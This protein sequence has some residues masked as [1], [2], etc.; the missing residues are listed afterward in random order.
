MYH[1]ND[2][3]KLF[4]RRAMMLAGGKATLIVGLAARMYYL[5]VMEA[6]KYAMQA[7]DNRITTRLLAPPRGLILDRNGI[8][9]AINQQ[10]YRVMVVAEQTPSLD[11][12]LDAL[13]KIIPIGE[14]ERARIHKEARRRRRFVPVS[15]REN[16]TWEEVARVEVNAPDLPGIM[17][18]V[19][20]SRYYPM[21]S[22]G[23][24]ILG[25]VAAVSEND[26]TD[27]PLEELPGFRIG[28]GG[29]ERVYD[30]ALRGRAGTLSLEVNSVGRIHRELERKEGEP[31]IDLNLTLDTRLQQY[32]AQRLGDESAAVVVM[33]ILTGD[34][35]VMASTPSFDPNS[36]NRGLSNDEWKELTSNPRSPLTNKVI[37]GQFAPGST[38]KLVSAIA[39][40]ESRDITPDMRVLCTGHMQLGSIK[41]HCW[42]K[43]GHGAQDMISGLKNSC[44]VYFYE[45]ARRVGFEKIAEMARRFGLGSPTGVDLP[46]ERSGLIP[47]R[48]W[49]RKALKQPWHPGETLINAI[50]QG[51]VTATPIQ[52]A[53]MTARIANGGYAVVPHVARDQVVE[54][55][56]HPRPPPEWPSLEVSRQSLAIVRKG[57]FAVSNEPGGTAYKARITQEGMWLSGKTGSAQVRRITMRERETGVKKN[58]QLPWKERDHA[59]FVAYAPEENPRYSIAVVVEHGGGGSAVAAPIARDIMLEVQKRDLA[60]GT[61]EADGA[62]EPPPD[63]RRF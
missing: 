49:K 32:A 30:M 52:L 61:A 16:L 8:A 53:V 59:L 37:A 26:L 42:K 7:E 13:G 4:S 6:D 38:F 54:K 25:Y 3:A 35:V 11:Y 9:M 1:D 36:F 63:F 33:D 20:Q 60:R 48:A 56:V 23:A 19:G 58:E 45:V 2:R 5:Q 17:I 31:G 24:H 10:N 57:M 55:S 21:E 15:V 40:L 12:T 34:I 22:L 14:S 62:P 43:E 46:S 28:K 27:D 44:D 39:A 47:D 50:G 51:Y 41:F 29:V 18:D